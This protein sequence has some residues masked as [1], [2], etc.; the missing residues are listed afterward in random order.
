[1]MSC[2][3]SVGYLEFHNA[4]KIIPETLMRTRT[5]H[6]YPSFPPEYVS[7]IRGVLSAQA[8][9]H[10]LVQDWMPARTGMTN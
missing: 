2:A 5:L 6:L 3:F 10:S 8:G 1:M 9:T 7:P 4:P